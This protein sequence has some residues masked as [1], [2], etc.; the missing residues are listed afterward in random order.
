MLKEVI[1]S[2]IFLFSLGKAIFHSLKVLNW[3][4][5]LIKI[6]EDWYSRYY[7][8][9]SFCKLFCYSSTT[10]HL[11]PSFFLSLLL[12][13]FTVQ[14]LSSNCDPF[15]SGHPTCLQFTANMMKSVVKYRWQCIEC[16]TC[17]LCG[18]SE[19]DVSVCGFIYH[20]IVMFSWKIM[21]ILS[22][23]TW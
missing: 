6:C 18:T 5:G 15:F 10:S 11:L 17:T 21:K 16:K 9:S 7:Q 1:Y 14:Q 20:V 19:N 2:L 23:C 12:L 3:I 22:F 8:L 4:T 13:K